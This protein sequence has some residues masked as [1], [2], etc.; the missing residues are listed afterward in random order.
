MYKTVNMKNNYAMGYFIIGRTMGITT[1]KL[2]N[3]GEFSW[4]RVLTDFRTKI[5]NTAPW[6][7]MLRKYS[8]H[9]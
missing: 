9:Q 2:N 8:E 6:F 7:H 5:K 3:S 4:D 1:Q